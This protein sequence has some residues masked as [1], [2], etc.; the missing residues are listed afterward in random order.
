[1]RTESFLNSD[2]SGEDSHVLHLLLAL[3]RAKFL[4]KLIVRQPRASRVI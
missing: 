1:M 4:Q 2:R 3:G